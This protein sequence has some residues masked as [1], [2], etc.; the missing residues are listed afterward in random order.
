MR[1]RMAQGDTAQ[2][3]AA[4]LLQILDRKG[5]WGLAS[6]TGNKRHRTIESVLQCSLDLLSNE[7]RTHLAELTIF[8]EDVA[9]PLGAAAALWSLDEFEAEETAQRF[10]RL[11]LLK[12]DLAR[13]SVRHPRCNSAVANG[14]CAKCSRAAQSPRGRMARSDAPARWLCVAMAYVAFGYGQQAP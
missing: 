6:E 8:P 10:A 12:L 2:N 4:R 13:G 1:Q 14:S 7:D 5:P 3:A 11:Y 9:I